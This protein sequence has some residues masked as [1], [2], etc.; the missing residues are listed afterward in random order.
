MREGIRRRALRCRLI[1][2]FSL[3]SRERPGNHCVRVLSVES[4]GTY[5]IKRILLFIPTFVAITIVTFAISRLAPGDPA[6]LKAGVGGEQTAD[7][8][9][10][11]EVI[12]KIREQW[13]LDKPV[14]TQ[15]FL[16]L[17]QAA[18]FDFGRSFKDNSP[19][20]DKLEERVPVTLGMN[21]VAIILSYLIAIP[22]GIYSAARP[23]TALDRTSAITM[24]VLYSLPSFWIGTMAIVFL[25]DPTYLN[26]FP[27]AGIH[28]PDYNVS[29]GF[30][31]K[32]W[33]VTWHLTL[34]V[35]VYAYAS[36][37]FLSRQ[38]RASMMETIGQDYIR[39]ARA[40]GLRERTVIMKHALRNS[41][42]PIITLTAGI[43][44]GLV[45]GSVIVEQIFSIPGMGRLAFESVLER[46]YP[47]VMAV[48][49]ISA[50]L[51]MLG[52]LVADLMYSV[53]DPR[54]AFSKK[55]S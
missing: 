6:E 43:L 49:T 2:I 53:V 48:L 54:I 18:T 23:G 29:W 35:L 20:I 15:Y 8:Q 27:P 37:A 24:F 9:V 11:A 10:T 33:D 1:R 51:T 40:K 47:I 12:K 36:F 25:A 14:T 16:W 21:L 28:S 7:R 3:F 31:Q 5:I 32:V 46:D 38:M 45:S 50:L 30:F 17:G 19:V 26:L 4:M 34:P 55:A 22:I 42:I 39:T 41:L 13:N 44:P 52:V